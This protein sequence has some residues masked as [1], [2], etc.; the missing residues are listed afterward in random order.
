LK[1]NKDD[2]APWGALVDA[3]DDVFGLIG[4]DDGKRYFIQTGMG[5]TKLVLR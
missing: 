3:V 1:G 5:G 2:D 4:H